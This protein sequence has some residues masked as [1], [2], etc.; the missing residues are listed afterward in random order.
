[1]DG[2]E[3]QLGHSS[4]SLRVPFL[5]SSS[6]ALVRPII[7]YNVICHYVSSN[8]GVNKALTEA[9]LEVSPRTVNL[10]TQMLRETKTEHDVYSKSS[11]QEIPPKSSRI[12]R[13]YVRIKR[14]H[15]G[16][17]KGL[18]TPSVTEDSGLVMSETLLT[19]SGNHNRSMIFVS[20]S[21]K[22]QTN[23]VVILKKNTY[24]GT[25]EAVSS[26]VNVNSVNI[27]SAETMD[28]QSTNNGKWDPPVLLPTDKL[29]TEDQQKVKQLLFEVHPE[30]EVRLC[31]SVVCVR[32]KD[33]SLRLC[34]DY[35]KINQKSV[36]DS[37]PLPKIQDALDSLG[38]SK[39]FSLLDQGKAYKCTIR[40]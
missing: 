35:R 22:N 7:G 26:S 16:Q 38:G 29:N 17:W 3:F 10:I 34:V 20:V 18:F 24:L 4:T 33:G 2:L 36:A 21:V 14:N 5:V 25:L 40:G 27:L 31:Q 8:E 13:A 12:I 6:T 37:R 11:A 39:W 19:V 1:M 30:V 28:T 32:K 15:G 9:L 23:S